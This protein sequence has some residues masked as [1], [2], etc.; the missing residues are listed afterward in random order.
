M[1][2]TYSAMDRRT[3]LKSAAAVG[4]TS[5]AGCMGGDDI[6]QIEMAIS[7]TGTTAGQAA[8]ALQ[9]ALDEHS[10]S[11]SLTLQE[12]GG[13]PASVR[14]F[15]D[16]DVEA[17]TA[18]NYLIG[19][20]AAERDPFDD[21]PVESLPNQG[22]QF[23]ILSFAWYGIGETTFETS[24]DVVGADVWPLNP[25]W[26]IRQAAEEVHQHAGVWDDLTEGVVNV[27]HNDVAGAIEEERIE[28]MIAYS[29]N[30][31][32]LPGWATEVDSRAELTYIEPSEQLI[33]GAEETEGAI[34]E[35]A[36]LGAWEQDVGVDE[37]TTW[38]IP[39]QF[40]FSDD[41]S[42]DI[43]YEI[44]EI[45]YEHYETAREAMA[46]Y[47]DH[48]DLD[49]M[50]NYLDNLPLHDGMRNFYDDHDYDGDLPEE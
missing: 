41:I 40:F 25:E 16:G 32:G 12:S 3:V 48:S 22:F 50:A 2:N 28:A 6:E 18:T 26:G 27:G 21:P 9:R 1:S 13:D 38:A 35:N 43:V 10:D 29:Q 33:E 5:I 47:F 8:Q 49:N 44:A 4:L 39:M 24:D 42:D 37:G 23:A 17:T 46:N 15:D 36:T 19:R 11:V 14:L 45:S 30:Y 7:A 31:E 34:V 20:A